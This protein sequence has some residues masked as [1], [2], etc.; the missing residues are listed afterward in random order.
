MPESVNNP[1]QHVLPPDKKPKKRDIVAAQ[2]IIADISSGVYRSPAAALKEL[3]SN[4]Y[5][6]DA[7]RVT[8]TTDAPHFRTLVIEDDGTGMTIE[9]FLDVITHIGGSRK[10]ID[11]ETSEVF[12]RKLIGRIG[13][14]MLAVAQL[15]NRFYVSSTVKGSKKRFAAEVNLEAFHRDDAALKNMAKIDP[16]RKVQIGAVRYVDDLPEATDL[17]YT[18]ITVPDAKKGLISE[19][20][21]AVRKAVGAHELLTVEAPRIDNFTK[22][23]ETVRYSQRGDLVLD[24]YYYMLSGLA[25]L[26]PLNYLENGP[27]ELSH[28][29]IEGAKGFTAPKIKSFQLF[30]DGIELFRPQLFPNTKAFDYPSPDPKVYPLEYDREVAGRHL[31]FTGYIYSQQPRIHPEEF[32]GI[33]IRIRNVG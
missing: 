15:G 6:A 13:I 14:G 1:Q 26:S 7:R 20:T 2:K 29:N 12:K 8:I 31:R 17:Q 32:K 28:R 21:S 25:L 3:I 23:V 18:V 22:L 33:H 10:R 16:E 24:G 19:M 9:K 5:D 4:A 30:V 11:G 27:F